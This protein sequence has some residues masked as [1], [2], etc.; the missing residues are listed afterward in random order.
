M[1]QHDGGLRTGHEHLQLPLTVIT[2]ASSAALA[3]A[4]CGPRA[5][6][7]TFHRLAPVPASQN[8]D[9][10]PKHQGAGQGGPLMRMPGVH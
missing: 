2:H 10:T 4:P 3:F 9:H 6:P 1:N 7:L 5:H 8:P